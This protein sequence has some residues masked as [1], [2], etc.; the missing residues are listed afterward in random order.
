MVLYCCVRVSAY[1]IIIS[2]CPA[3]I[4]ASQQSFCD[5]VEC[6]WC[7]YISKLSNIDVNSKLLY[8]FIYTH[9]C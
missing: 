9:L 6:N 7:K 3:N 2:V 4:I 1:I 8:A 5:I